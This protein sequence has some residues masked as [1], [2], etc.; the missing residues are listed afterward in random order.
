MILTPFP[1][2]DNLLGID[3]RSFDALSAWSADVQRQ[4]A[5]EEPPYTLSPDDIRAIAASMRQAVERSFDPE[6][7]QKTVDDWFECSAVAGSNDFQI[8]FSYQA[9][10]AWWRNYDPSSGRY[11]TG[12]EVASESVADICIEIRWDEG[13]EVVYDEARIAEAFLSPAVEL[14]ENEE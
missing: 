2:I 10:L 7:G 4:I 3:T 5:A 13:R 8:T 9:R 11:E 6:E 1:S 12:Y 14:P